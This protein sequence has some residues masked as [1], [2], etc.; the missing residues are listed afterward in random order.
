[1]LL[2]SDSQGPDGSFVAFNIGMAKSILDRLLVFPVTSQQQRRSRIVPLPGYR[3]RISHSQSLRDLIRD[4]GR[5]MQ[6]A[7]EPHG[8]GRT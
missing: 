6:L 4:I 7:T 2:R 3:M 1:M 5:G 8:T